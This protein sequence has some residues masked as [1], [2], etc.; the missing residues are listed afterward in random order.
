MSMSGFEI[1]DNDVAAVTRWL[2][3]FH[4]E[5]ANLD[6][7]RGM[8]VNIKLGYRHVGWDDPDQL[9]DYYGD[10]KNRSDDQNGKTSDE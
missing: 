5:D 7:A 1:T 9:E 8:L 3:I 6:F 4:P 2:K 10:Y